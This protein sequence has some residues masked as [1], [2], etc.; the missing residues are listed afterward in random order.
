M[1]NKK[2]RPRKYTILFVPDDAS[3]VRQLKVSLDFFIILFIVALFTIIGTVAYIIHS[4]GQIEDERMQIMALNAQLEEVTKVNLMLD[5]DN[6]R[7]Q[8]ELLAANTALDTKT[9]IEQQTDTAASLSYIPSGLPISG[10]ISAPSEFKDGAIT[11]T[12]G[13]GAWIVASG[14]GTVSKIVSDP[15]QGYI[16]EV[17]HGNEYLSIYRY[18]TVPLVKEGTKVLRGTYIFGCVGEV[19]QFSYSVNYQGKPI[20]PNT[21][22]KIDG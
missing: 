10:S 11:F 19:P 22:M 21:I 8:N 14:D 7:L 17:D 18:V 16:V 12:V 20:D 1:K 3:G 6:E 15:Q 5:A 2:K 13:D 4:A 9:Y